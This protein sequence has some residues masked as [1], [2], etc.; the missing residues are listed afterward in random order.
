MKS[1]SVTFDSLNS[2]EKSKHRVSL[3]PATHLGSSFNHDKLLDDIL[4]DES[5][6]SGGIPDDTFDRLI[7]LPFQGNYLLKIK[8]ITSK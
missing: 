3:K 4:D 8:V 7:D 1:I 2:K 6:F 5:L